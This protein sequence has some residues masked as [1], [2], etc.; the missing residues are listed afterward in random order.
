MRNVEI[1][2]LWR[3]DSRWFNPLQSLAFIKVLAWLYIYRL[4]KAEAHSWK[5]NLCKQSSWHHHTRVIQP[6]NSFIQKE[7]PNMW[8]GLRKQGMWAHD[9]C[10]LFQSFWTHNFLSQHSMAMTISAVS[11]NLFGIM[12]QVIS[13]SNQ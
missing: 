1:G 2:C 4:L 7:Y 11:K 6:T 12:M 8:P 13:V 3:L 10:L 9:F 5:D